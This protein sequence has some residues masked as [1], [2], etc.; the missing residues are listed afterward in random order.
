MNLKEYSSKYNEIEI[1][2]RGNFGA[3]IL[4]ENLEEKNIYSKKNIIGKS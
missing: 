3:A 1:I 4:V 2:G